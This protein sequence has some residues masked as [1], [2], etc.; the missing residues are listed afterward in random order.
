MTDVLNYGESEIRTIES[1]DETWYS[2]IDV[3]AILTDSPNPNKYW[4]VLKTRL[5]SE[6]SQLTTECSKFKL[7]AADGKMR[8]TDCLDRAGIFRLIQSVPSPNAEPFKVWLSEA[9]AM[10]MNEQEDP[11]LI[12]DR[13]IQSYTKDGRDPEW[14]NLRIANLAT[15]NLLTRAWDEH[16]VKKGKEYAY[17]TD[18]IHKGTFGLNTREH[19]AYKD[20]Q[21]GDGSLRDNLS[22]MELIFLSL[23]EE[24][25]RQLI[26]Q[27]N[28]QGFSQN[29]V[30]AKKGG[31]Q[32]G[33]S[34]KNLEGRLGIKAL[35]PRKW[36]GK[37][38]G[39]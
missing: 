13:L 23:G 4:S 18:D 20:I 29:Q 1:G 16:G 33:I 14:I 35:N 21:K 25:T 39:S 36:F 9:G 2:V 31:S 8:S 11:Q 28:P 30:L 12:Y 10:V 17:L 6:G 3:I 19:R 26:E 22:N 5:A 15:R 34:R 32:A 38:K 24:I 37:K 27:H 7:K